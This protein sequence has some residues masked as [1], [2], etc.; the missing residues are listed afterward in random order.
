MG[1]SPRPPG[2][3]PARI[4]GSKLAGAL[5]LAMGV[6]WG[7]ADHGTASESSKGLA[8][9]EARAWSHLERL[10]GLG[11]RPS[12]SASAEAARLYFEEALRGAGLKPERESFKELTPAG[13]ID[14]CNVFAD[15]PPTSAAKEA[16]W[17]LLCTHYDTKR[18][19]G[20][21]VGANDGGS[22]TAVLLEL[23]RCMAKAP[24]D[25]FGYRF[26]FLDGEEAVNHDWVDPDNRYGS[27]HHAKRLQLSGKASSFRACVLL[28][29]VGDK[30]LRIRHESYSDERIYR[31]FAEA[32]KEL[33]LAKHFATERSGPILDDHLSFMAIDIRSVDLIDFEYGPNNAYWHSLDDTLENCSKQSLGITGRVVL[34]ALPKLE[35][36]LAR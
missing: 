14:F 19:A 26:L 2:L 7:C 11:P 15:L 36:S 28:D 1:S 35:A 12:G 22:G 8:F 27:R 32:A 17:I 9:D 23:A 6:A 29:M 21:F 31:V 20:N 18:L 30:D 16:D 3:V 25:R 24:S 10:V 33:G 5:F 34:H 13:E 4:H